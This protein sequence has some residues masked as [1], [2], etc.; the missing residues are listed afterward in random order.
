LLFGAE[1]LLD[2]YQ[3]LADPRCLLHDSLCA[4]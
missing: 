3:A 2:G 1:F 4:Y